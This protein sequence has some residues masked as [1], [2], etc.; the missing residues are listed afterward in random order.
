MKIFTA[1]REMSF[2]DGSLSKPNCAAMTPLDIVNRTAT[3]ACRPPKKGTRKLLVSV[4]IEAIVSIL[5][6]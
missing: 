2:E 5:L 4:T 6:C 1:V 3:E